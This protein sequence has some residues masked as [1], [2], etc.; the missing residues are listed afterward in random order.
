[1]IYTVGDR[2]P[3]FRG[4]YYVAPDATV[5]GSVVLERDASVWFQSV[6]RGDNDRITIG[7]RSNVQD[8]CVLHVDEGVPLTL[9]ADVSVGHQVVL[10]GCTI[11]DGCLIGINSTILNNTVIGAGSIVGANS[12]VAENK[13]IPPRSLV[14]GSPGRVVRT[15]SEEKS[16]ALLAFAR[17]YVEKSRLYRESLRPLA[18][19]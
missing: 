18:G 3:E 19:R 4:D 5:I 14:L 6:V 1:V 8:A 2:R 13:T 17:H 10:H 7:E 11:E 9:G 12:L 15:L 16:A